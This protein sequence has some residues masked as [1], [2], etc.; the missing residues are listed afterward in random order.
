MGDSLVHQ[1]RALLASELQDVS[2]RE[3]MQ[4]ACF[5]QATRGRYHRHADTDGGS[6]R[7]LTAIYYLNENWKDEEGGELRMFKSGALSTH[8]RCDIL[9]AANRLVLF[10]SDHRCPHEVLSTQRDRWAATVWYSSGPS[11]LSDFGGGA[12][13]LNAL[14]AEAALPRSAVALVEKFLPAAPLSFHDGLRIA[15]VSEEPA[16][17]IAQVS[18]FVRRQR[19]TCS[20][21]EFRRMIRWVVSHG[22]EIPKPPKGSKRKRM[23]WQTSSESES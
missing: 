3:E 7:R 15:G 16:R 4:V 21:E 19:S 8:V 12:E 18:D 22:G 23:P 20:E 9:P 10:W 14:Q 13:R 1:L 5:R 6:W 2:F 11:I 17:R